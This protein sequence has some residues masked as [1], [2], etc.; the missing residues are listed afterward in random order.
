MEHSL[1]LTLG[2]DTRAVRA[3]R[4]KLRGWLERTPCRSECP[5]DVELVV[6]ELVT[7]AL[8]HTRTTAALRATLTERA[9]HIEVHDQAPIPPHV[10][11]AQGAA[12]GFGLHIV[13]A[14]AVDWGWRPTPDGKVVW[15]DVPR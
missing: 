3:A 1:A 8:V 14:L 15:A 7:N 4:A 13:D 2:N 5:D 9:V 10:R 11:E 12:G 6:S